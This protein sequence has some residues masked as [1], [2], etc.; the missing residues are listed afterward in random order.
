MVKVKSQVPHFES[1]SDDN[2]K[3]EIE[4]EWPQS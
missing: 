3:G 4:N 1:P 2:Y